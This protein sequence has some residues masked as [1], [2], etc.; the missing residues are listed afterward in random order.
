MDTHQQAIDT[1]TAYGRQAPGHDAMLTE[2]GPG[3]PCGEFMRRYWQ[4]AALSSEANATP[5]QVR[6]LGE[7]LILFRDGQGRAGLVHARCAHRGTTL[8]Y[9][10]VEERGIR[11]C[12]HGWLF[13]VEG[14]CLDQP[15]E[16]EGGVHRDK[17]RQ[18]WYPVRERYGIVFAY[19]G[20]P[21]KQ[22]VLPRF[23]ILEDVPEGQ[24]LIAFDNGLG[25]GGDG[26][27]LI[28]PCNWLQHWENI[29]DPFH[30]AILHSA[31]SGTQFVP[32]MAVMPEVS[33]SYVAAGVRSTQIRRLDAGRVLR[34]VTEVMFPSLRLVPSPLLA[35]GPS[36]SIGW[37]VPVDDTHYK[38]ITAMKVSAGG[39]PPRGSVYDGKR[40]S[41]LGEAEHQSMPGDYEA[42]TGQGK[43]TLHSEEN[44]ATTDQGVGMLRRLLRQQIETVAAGG[45]PAGVVFDVAGETVPIATGNYFSG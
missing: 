17:A 3:T 11:C 38:I 14:N 23:D 15:C 28:A 21:A 33:F 8:Y 18:P 9:G 26:P 5:R 45:D 34:R 29:M 27:G 35:P 36:D 20:P 10:K 24:E 42:Q 37:T 40:W 31:F 12:Y 30:V 22:P 43:I 7:D 32:E 41:E 25:T 39:A 1:G 16:L 44:L 6:L 13:D 2:V 4:P 19:M